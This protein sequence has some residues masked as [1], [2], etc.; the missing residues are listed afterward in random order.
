MRVLN[1]AGELRGLGDGAYDRVLKQNINGMHYFEFKCSIHS[2]VYKALELEGY[3]DLDSFGEFTIK[4]IVTHGT[5]CTCKCIMNVDGIVGINWDRFASLRNSLDDAMS[6]AL[7]GTGWGC[8]NNTTVTDIRN[9]FAQNISSWDVIQ[10]ICGIYAV[11]ITFDT[12]SKMVTLWDKQG[13]DV[14]MFFISRLN[15]KEVKKDTHTHNLITK[16]KPLGKDGLTVASVNGGSEWITNYTYSNKVMEAVWE[17]TRYEDATSLMKDAQHFLDY[18]AVPYESYEISISD[19]AQMNDEYAHLAYGLG[20]V[21]VIKDHVQQLDLEHRIIYIER[22]LDNPAQNRINIANK[23]ASFEAYYKRLSLISE[24]LKAT[25]NEDGTIASDMYDANGTG[26][27]TGEVDWSKIPNDIVGAN[28]IKAESIQSKHIVAGAITSDSIQAGAI[29][30]IHLNSGII[31]GNHI[32]AGAITAGSAIIA[33]GA[34]GSAQIGSLDA[35][36]ITSGRINTSVLDI[37]SANGRLTMNGETLIIRDATRTRVQ[38]GK[39]ANDDYN[40]YLVD[41]NG[42]IMFNAS[43][44]TGDGIKSPIIKDG[45]ITDDANISGSKLNISSVINNINNDGSTTIKASKIYLDTEK[46]ALSTAF[47]AINTTV[48]GQTTQISNINQS[49]TGISSTVG[50]LTTDTNTLKSQMNTVQQTQSSHTVSIS[51]ITQELG[52]TTATANNAFAQSST[53]KTALESWQYEQMNSGGYNYIKNSIIWKGNIA[54]NTVSNQSASNITTQI[55]KLSDG[56]GYGIKGWQSTATAVNGR[57]FGYRISDLTP[58]LVGATY[59]A[60]LDMEVIGKYGATNVRLMVRQFAGSAS[61][62]VKSDYKALNP[63]TGAREYIDFVLDPTTTFFDIDVIFNTKVEDIGS[64]D[65]C[66]FISRPMVATKGRYDWSLAQDEVYGG[67]ITMNADGIMV[68]QLDG[69]STA[70]YSK[71]D[72]QGISM[73]DTLG[74]VRAWFGETDTAYIKELTADKI[75]SDSIVC[76]AINAPDVLYVS[77]GGSGDRTGTSI[78]NMAESVTSALEQFKKNYGNYLTTDLTVYIGSGTYYGNVNIIGFIGEGRIRLIFNSDA[79]T[80]G[81]I[82]YKYNSVF[83]TVIGNQDKMWSQT[84]MDNNTDLPASQFLFYGHDV[85][86]EA[87]E[88]S[89]KLNLHVIRAEKRGWTSNYS[90]H[91]GVFIKAIASEV[92]ATQCDIVGFE[93]FVDADYHSTIQTYKCRGHVRMWGYA[94]GGCKVRITGY[95]PT[96]YNEVTEREQWGGEIV[97]TATDKGSVWK[98]IAGGNGVGEST[99]I[100]STFG[101][102]FSASKQF[103][104]TDS[105]DTGAVTTSMVN[106]WGMGRY[107]GL[108]AHRGTAEFA[109]ITDHL[110]GATNVSVTCTMTRNSSKGGGTC[111]P[112]VW[113]GSSYVSVGVGYTRGQ[114]ATFTLTAGMISYLRNNGKLLMYSTS[115]SDYSFYSNTS[116]YVTCTKTI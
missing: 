51:N 56:L 35:G 3:I 54:P 68:D 106:M 105:G 43:G 32:Q 63:D 83:C 4:E 98:P 96:A 21:V 13:S 38:I 45:M 14:G 107:T 31:T 97:N 30:A 67:V 69:E 23:D 11:E 89:G 12:R 22:H 60:S 65:S 18:Y 82:V 53:V 76:K 1:G 50:S 64:A 104:T 42:K 91:Q 73:Y 33:N 71:V 55:T 17:Q 84:E 100:S 79:K 109:G 36:K 37:G 62:V 26:N 8:N 49:L 57:Y 94:N 9:V 20:D 2:P 59:T 24:S 29:K 80:Y 28:N 95:R 52:T 66:I 61:T 15:L 116:L 16:L 39:D 81:R 5:L 48:S 44:L 90:N 111:Y 108:K 40:M 87:T 27:G 34:I 113:D 99:G 46:Q 86:V 7:S 92:Y 6:L 101:T 75:K 114:T 103:T 10:K 19:L 58:Y 85:C 72:S 110:Y 47:S 115:T 70:G 77:V 74:N 78:M 93:R 88:N 112:K 25:V 102:K 41:A